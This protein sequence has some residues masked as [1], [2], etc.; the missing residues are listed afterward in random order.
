MQPNTRRYFGGEIGPKAVVHCR[1]R[2]GEGRWQ[3]TAPTTRHT[4]RVRAFA[5]AFKER[6][7]CLERTA[8]PLAGKEPLESSPSR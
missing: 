3:R 2:V 6:S 7:A 8:Q 5:R 4:H 1:R